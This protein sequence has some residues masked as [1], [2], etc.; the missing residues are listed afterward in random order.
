MGS[1]TRPDG[2]RQLTVAGMPVYRYSKDAK[3]GQVTGEGAGGTWF[4]SMPEEGVSAL[5]KVLADLSRGQ[6]GAT[7]LPGATAGGDSALPGMSI[8]EH[9]VLGEILVDRQGRTLYRFTKDTDWPMTS[10]CTGDCLKQWSVAELIEKNDAEGIDP[11]LVIPF[12]RADGKKQQTIDCWPLYTFA[13][14]KAP[15]DAKGQGVNGSWFAVAADGSLVKGS[16]TRHVVLRSAGVPMGGRYQAMRFVRLRVQRRLEQLRTHTA[17]EH[18]ALLP[19]TSPL[20]PQPPAG[21]PRPGRRPPG[22]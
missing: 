15:G 6:G 22:C 7:A 14:D 16:A 9:P 10:A 18:T 17:A 8:A 4:A 2:V 13:G 19:P 11:K 21:P 5:Q 12:N 20:H 3:P 1:L